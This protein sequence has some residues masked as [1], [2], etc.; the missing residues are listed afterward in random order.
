MLIWYC[1]SQ[2]EN[3]DLNMIWTCN[4]G[5]PVCHST[6]WAI[7][8]TGIGGEFLSYLNVQDILV[9]TFNA[10]PWEDVCTVFQFNF[11]II[12]SQLKN[13]DSSGIWTLI[14][15]D[16]LCDLSFSSNLFS[17]MKALIFNNY[18]IFYSSSSITSNIILI[19]EPFT[20]ETNLSWYQV[21]RL[22]KNFLFSL[23]GSYFAYLSYYFLFLTAVNSAS[24]LMTR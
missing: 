22:L 8:S 15:D 2:L 13:V 23:T 10:Y 5:I 20:I 4:L 18:K 1:W 7:K 12:L 16:W 21:S 3:I 24:L 6:S 11:R 9:T 17:S 14:W 19:I